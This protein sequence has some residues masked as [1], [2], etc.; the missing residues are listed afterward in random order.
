MPS[1]GLLWY[2]YVS[3]SLSWH[4]WLIS[5]SDLCTNVCLLVQIKLIILV[6]TPRTN[7][8]SKKS[9]GIQSMCKLRFWTG[10]T[11]VLFFSFIIVG[12]LKVPTHTVRRSG[13]FWS[14]G[15]F[16]LYHLTSFYLEKKKSFFNIFTLTCSPLRCP[17][18]GDYQ[19]IKLVPNDL[20][21]YPHYKRFMFRMFAFVA[22]SSQKTT[23]SAQQ[24]LNWWEPNKV[25]HAN[26]H[27]CFPPIGVHSLQHIH[28]SDGRRQHVR[29]TLP[30]F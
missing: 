19:N 20:D 11:L 12:Q 25:R 29:A 30:P 4:S 3:L 23:T 5:A 18:S 17:N 2:L 1:K 10:T 13:T 6:S 21:T 28:L 15:N 14:M 22:Q 24:V 8:L 9:W 27:C 26:I 7:I 16:I